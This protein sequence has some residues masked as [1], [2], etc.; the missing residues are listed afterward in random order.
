[1]NTGFDFKLFKKTNLVFILAIITTSSTA[2]YAA[3]LIFMLYSCCLSLYITHIILRCICRFGGQVELVI[4]SKMRFSLCGL[5]MRRVILVTARLIS[6]MAILRG[7]CL[8]YLCIHQTFQIS[9]SL[10]IYL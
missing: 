3:L 4:S 2:G 10:N 9:I 7:I 1:M 8:V 6:L 5:S